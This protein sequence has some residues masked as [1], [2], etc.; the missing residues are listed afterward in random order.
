MG[1]GWDQLKKGVGQHIGTTNPGKPGNMVVSAHNDVF[2]EIF[3][4][5]DKLKTGDQ[6]ILFTNAR[7]I[8][9]LITNTQI[10][11][12]TET[13]VMEDTPIRHRY[14]DLVLPVYGR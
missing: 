2:G 3:R 7:S 14:I 12:P 8:F 1:D 5:L 9:I 13:E 4:D 6:I 11:E 10:V